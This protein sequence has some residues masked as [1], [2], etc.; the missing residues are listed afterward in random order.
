MAQELAVNDLE[1]PA[2]SMCAQNW[3]IRSFRFY[4]FHGERTHKNPHDQI[5]ALRL[6]EHPAELIWWGISA[7]ITIA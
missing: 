6:R 3:V 4:G 2:F 5:W 1:P 7:Q